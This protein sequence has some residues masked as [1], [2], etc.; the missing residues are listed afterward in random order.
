[1]RDVV[2]VDDGGSSKRLS[3]NHACTKHTAQTCSANAPAPR[4]ELNALGPRPAGGDVHC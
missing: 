4:D 3:Q 2:Q 1:M